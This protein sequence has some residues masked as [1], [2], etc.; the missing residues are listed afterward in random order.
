M[1]RPAH[2]IVV[3]SFIT[4]TCTFGL[5]P[6][7]FADGT[8]YAMTNQLTRSGGN[9]ILVYHRASNGKLSLIQTIATTG[10]GSGIQLDPTDSLASQGGLILDED[11]ERLFA[12]NT[13]TVAA[14]L[15]SE[16]GFP[17]TEVGDC[18][19]GTI[20][21]FKVAPDGTLTFVQKVMSG[22]L[23]PNSLTIHGHLLYVL[24][25]GGPGKNPVCGIPPNITGFTLKGAKMTLLS[26]STRPISPGMPPFGF[27]NCDNSTG[28]FA[29]AE[30][31]CGN[32]PP[33]FPRAPA[34]IMFTANGK[35]LVVT[36]KGPNKIY[37]FPVL[38]DGTPG[39]PTVHTAT[40]PGQPAYFGFAFD[41]E[42]HLIVSEPFGATS[43]I[44]AVPFSAV[45]SFSIGEDGSLTAISSSVP[46]SEGTSCW[47]VLAGRHAYVGNNA[48]SNI[49]SYTIGSNGSLTLL[50][51]SA[52]MVSHPNDLA[53]AVEGEEDGGAS[54]LY[55]LGAG[56][57][58]VGV[59][60]IMANGSLTFVQS[61]PG[62]PV[63]MGAQGLAAY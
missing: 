46:N 35:Q 23:F 34:Q 59:W 14:D 17:G 18:S 27:L 44:P 51:H 9:N 3:L 11:H 26:G 4:V 31:Q 24:N 15:G 19:M 1:K 39:A 52:A 6:S 20:S 53:V 16:P 45:S 25:A 40:G 62:L 29:T 61:A 43:V 21:S 56:D 10:G 60:R 41:E 58:T 49:S 38:E 42:G 54:F 37:V 28:P 36:V 47:V 13:E 7:T 30:F 55:A 5:A 57:G 63:N 8:V 2:W 33:A 32:N 50:A 22:G 12:V 48:T